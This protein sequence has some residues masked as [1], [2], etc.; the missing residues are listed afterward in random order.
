MCGGECVA[1]ENEHGGYDE[2]M[3]GELMMSMASQTSIS[4]GHGECA[5]GKGGSC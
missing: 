5:K 1:G 2:C 4:G 3:Y